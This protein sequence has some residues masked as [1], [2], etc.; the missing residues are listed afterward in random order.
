MSTGYVILF[1]GQ[2]PEVPHVNP[3]RRRVRDVVGDAALLVLADGERAVVRP[4]QARIPLIARRANIYQRAV[5]RREARVN[6]NPILFTF[7]NHAKSP[8]ES[9]R[10]M[11]V[12]FLGANVPLVPRIAPRL[13]HS[14]VAADAKI[15]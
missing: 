5:E 15:Y 6:I 11:L 2:R 13:L 14:V 3:P 10:S 7:D 12:L 8:D 9:S 4:R 1:L